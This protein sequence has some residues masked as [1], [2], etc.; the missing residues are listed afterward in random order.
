MAFI[1]WSD[2]LSVSVPTIDEQHKRLIAIVNDIHATVVAGAERTALNRIFDE[3]ISYT[4]YHFRTEEEFFE[5][6]HYADRELHKT[7]HNELTQKALELQETY[8]QGSATVSY[9][10]LDFLHDW[11]VTHIIGSDRQFGRFLAARGA[12]AV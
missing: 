12:T 1:Q 11:L 4:V 8:Q 6:F 5:K 9:E 3:L 7:Q 2:T 10:V